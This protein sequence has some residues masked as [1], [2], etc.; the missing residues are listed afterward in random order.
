MLWTETL[1]VSGM[2]KTRE[3]AW[4]G[5]QGRQS[6]ELMVEVFRAMRDN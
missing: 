4:V 3:T 1:E 6:S 5:I 2:F